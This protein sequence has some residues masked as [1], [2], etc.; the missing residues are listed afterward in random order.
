MLLKSRDEFRRNDVSGEQ[1]RRASRPDRHSPLRAHAACA[2]PREFCR[3]RL[4]C[5]DVEGES[6]FDLRRE[7][8]RLVRGGEPGKCRHDR[9]VI[10]ERIDEARGPGISAGA[11]RYRRCRNRCAGDEDAGARTHGDSP[12]N[13]Q[14]GTLIGKAGWRD[15]AAKRTSDSNSCRPRS[16]MG[17]VKS[18]ENF[19]NKSVCRPGV[20]CSY[21]SERKSLW[22]VLPPGQGS[23]RVILVTR[24]SV[25]E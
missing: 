6:R 20:E 16:R 1:L 23:Q 24:L 4:P 13:K 5:L 7:L 10:L 22:P 11:A 21:A 14:T 25:A 3:R 17:S 18:R 8:A 15:K 12:R 2:R 9:P 19:T